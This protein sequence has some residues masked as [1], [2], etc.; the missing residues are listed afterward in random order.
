MDEK[1]FSIFLLHPPEPGKLFNGAV[2]GMGHA[3]LV[4]ILVFVVFKALAK[5]V[6]GNVHGVGGVI[7]P[8]RVITPFLTVK[9]NRDSLQIY[10]PL[11]DTNRGMV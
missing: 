10:R 3:A 2:Y 4:G 9:L 5:F 7:F 11:L 8:G 6:P 1:P